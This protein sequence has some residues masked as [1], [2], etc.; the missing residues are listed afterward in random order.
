MPM[1]KI[2]EKMIK[3]TDKEKEN[4]KFKISG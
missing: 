2:K 3:R 1:R 4:E